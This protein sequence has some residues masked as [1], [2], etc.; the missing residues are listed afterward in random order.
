MKYYLRKKHTA[1]SMVEFALAV[2]IFL[3]LVFGIFEFGRLFAIYSAINT[4]SREAVRYGAAVGTSERGMPYFQD[5]TGIREAAQRIG[6]MSGL[7]DS[8]IDIRYDKGHDDPRDWNSLSACPLSAA[9]AQNFGTGDRIVVHIA[10][11]YRPLLFDFPIIPLEAHSGRSIIKDVDIYSTPVHTNVPLTP[12]TSTP[13][14]SNT[15]LTPSA[16]PTETLVPT[17]THTPTNTLVPSQ[18]PTPTIT[19][20]HSHTPTAT[21]TPTQTRTIPP[22][23]T[24]NCALYYS[25]SPNLINNVDY[26][27]TL[28]NATGL[29]TAQIT[30]ISISWSNSEW[31]NKLTLNDP[32]TTLWQGGVKESISL[33]FSPNPALELPPGSSRQLVL[34][35][36]KKPKTAVSLYI[37]LDNGCTIIK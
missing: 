29:E 18:T 36:S 25:E 37:S 7:Q 34:D 16:T 2:P 11:T 15:P 24:P 5:C 31:L 6:F 26:Q 32:N 3:M 17:Q 28:W 14:R 21:P 4:A 9:D 30:A 22:T 35:F 10:T 33:S 8:E 13:V 12:P 1:Q 19:P 20:L 27:Y 23:R